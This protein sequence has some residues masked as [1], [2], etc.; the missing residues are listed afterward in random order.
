MAT[1]FIRHRVADYAAWRR[2]YDSFAPTQKRLGVQ[3]EAV[4]QAA[5]DPRDITVSHDFATLEAAHAFAG[6][7]ELKAAMAA[8]GVQGA[9]TIWFTTRA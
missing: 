1:M 6:N 8:A 4:Y 2:V 5:D 7:A 9:P 3:A